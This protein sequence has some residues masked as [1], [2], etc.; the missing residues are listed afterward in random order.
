MVVDLQKT[1]KQ[2]KESSTRLAVAESKRTEMEKDVVDFRSKIFREYDI[3]P[4]FTD[5]YIMEYLINNKK[6]IEEDINSLL[7][8]LNERMSAVKDEHRGS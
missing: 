6:G 3:D 2:L 4:S 8:S 5:E 7:D 1:M